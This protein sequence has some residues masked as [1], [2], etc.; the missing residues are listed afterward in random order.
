MRTLVQF[1]VYMLLAVIAIV[2]GVILGNYGS[3]YFAWFVGTGMI[4]LVAVAGGTWMDTHDDVAGSDD[5]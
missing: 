5:E 4:V 1:L 2:F 3:W